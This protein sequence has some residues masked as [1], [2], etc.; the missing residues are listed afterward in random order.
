MLFGDSDICLDLEYCDYSMDVSID[1]TYINVMIPYIIKICL[2]ILIEVFF[3]SLVWIGIYCFL[4]TKF[5]FLK[6]IFT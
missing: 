4:L 2:I 6:E 5:T 1:Y 3:I